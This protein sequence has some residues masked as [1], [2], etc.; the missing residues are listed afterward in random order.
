MARAAGAHQKIIVQSDPENETRVEALAGA[1]NITPG[2][3]LQWSAGTL[4]V[5]AAAAGS[6]IPKLI[7]LESQHPDSEGTAG[8]AADYANG[9]T[10]YAW[11]PQP[12]DHALMWLAAGQTT[13]VHDLLVSDAA[14]A[15]TVEAGPLD[16]A[17]IVDSVVGRALNVVT[18]LN[19]VLVEIA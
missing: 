10:V 5:H 6:V 2:E 14:G 9:D 11:I 8:I 18:G 19:R 12:G 16:A 1:A 7:A 17:D 15:L 13:A 4:I 3:L